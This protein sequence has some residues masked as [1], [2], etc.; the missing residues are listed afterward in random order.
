MKLLA[1]AFLAFV[2]GAAF[3]LGMTPPSEPDFDHLR[4]F[5]RKVEAQY[6]FGSAVI[7]RPGYALTAQHV[8]VNKDL[9][10]VE[11]GTIGRVLATLEDPHGDLALVKY[12]LNEARCPC[13]RLADS[14]AQPD[15][16]VYVIGFPHG[17][18]SVVTIGRA[19]GVQSVNMS[20]PFGKSDLGSRLIITA[21]VS[22]GNSGGG[23]FV[24]RR[25]EFQLVGIMVEG[26]GSVFFAVPL[27]TI[28]PFLEV[29]YP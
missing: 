20:G 27:A 22:P 14:E 6:G 29:N 5:N 17:V 1:G 24:R 21:P 3:V 25:G 10:L 13:V 18:A 12:P 7:V 11:K 16:I 28:K 15:E 26:A 2:F 4:S 8:A 9:R 19:Q 23:V